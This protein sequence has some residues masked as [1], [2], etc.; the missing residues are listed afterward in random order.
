LKSSAAGWSRSLKGALAA[1]SSFADARKD[2]STQSVR[3]NFI[4]SWFCFDRGRIVIASIHEG[5][6]ILFAFK[7][8]SV[9]KDERRR[10]QLN[11][12]KGERKPDNE[13]GTST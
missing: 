10:R 2:S 8:T 5:R 1:T 4:S 7:A 12:H 9:G 11:G 6:P 13:G 3:A